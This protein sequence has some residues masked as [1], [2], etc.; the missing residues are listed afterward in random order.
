VILL[1][2]PLVILGLSLSS[3]SVS[4]QDKR[5]DVVAS[6]DPFLDPSAC[7]IV[8]RDNGMDPGFGAPG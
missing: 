1:R 2:S 3:S 4:E 6:E 7:R 8:P 5:S